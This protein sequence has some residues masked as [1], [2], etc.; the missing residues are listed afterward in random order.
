MSNGKINI[1]KFLSKYNFDYLVIEEYE[2]LYSYLLNNKKYE[3]VYKDT[4]YDKYLFK[5]KE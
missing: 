3:L 1:N 4:E 5:R 2:V